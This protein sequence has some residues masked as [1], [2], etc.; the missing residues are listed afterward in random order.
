MDI[1]DIF[2]YG[3]YSLNT[4]YLF[5]YIYIFFFFPFLHIIHR[6]TY[7]YIYTGLNYLISNYKNT[8]YINENMHTHEYLCT[9]L[10]YLAKAIAYEDVTSGD[11]MLS[12]R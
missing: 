5:I 2:L 8:Y 6:L 12:K 11:A 9:G 7:E 10:K 3:I 4:P 1:P